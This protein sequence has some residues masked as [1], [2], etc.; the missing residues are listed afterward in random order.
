MALPAF[1]LAGREPL[2][3]T[4]RLELGNEPGLFVLGKR[5]GDLPHHLARGIAAVGQVVAV[6]SENADAALD[7]RQ[8]AQLLR[9][10]LACEPRCILD[11]DGPDAI[12]LDPVQQ[13][14]KAGAGLN[15]V[16]AADCGIVELADQGESCPL[17]IAL[18]GGPLSLVAVL[19]GAD[20]GGR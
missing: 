11:N 20:V 15:R 6:G 12:A 16:S 1:A 8:D 18:D 19:V 14:G 13:G 7:Q 9:H 2:A 10:Q 17:G 5:S 4:C 3:F